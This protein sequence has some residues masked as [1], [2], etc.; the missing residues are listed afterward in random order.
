[1]AKKLTTAQKRAQYKAARL[2]KTEQKRVLKSATNQA[3][4]YELRVESQI[5]NL[6]NE[7]INLRKLGRSSGLRMKNLSPTL[8]GY[9]LSKFDKGFEGFS[10]RE[11]ET[12]L[13]NIKKELS[14]VLGQD[15]TEALAKG[16]LSV[17]QDQALAEEYAY[18]SYVESFK[19]TLEEDYNLSSEVVDDIINGMM[20]KEHYVG[21]QKRLSEQ[22]LS[23]RKNI[24][25][26]DFF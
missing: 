24:N 4:R 9:G 17:M 1:M 7:T 25:N 6:R 22:Q 21:N 13:K 18:S 10:L 11:K 19:A 12:A 23:W 8:K 20:T 16:E 3:K 5:R 14:Q 2:A 26:A 15:K